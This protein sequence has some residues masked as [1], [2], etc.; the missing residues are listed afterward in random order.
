MNNSWNIKLLNQ[1]VEKEL[2]RLDAGLK[3]KFLYV[4][5]LLEIFGPHQVGSPHTKHLR[6]DLW[7]I[8]LI[9]AGA[10][11]RAIY[12]TVTGQTIVVVHVFFKKTQKTPKRALTVALQRLKEIME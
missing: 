3:A 2:D 12:V 9:G 10:S 4:C 6:G 8:R 7:E 11:A 1:S 5:D